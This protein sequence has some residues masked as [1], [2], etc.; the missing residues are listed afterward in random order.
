MFD[1]PIFFVAIV[2]SNALKGDVRIWFKIPEIVIDNAI[3]M[4]LSWLCNTTFLKIEIALYHAIHKSS[5]G[6]PISECGGVGGH[7]S[8]VFIY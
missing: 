2:R 5:G 6:D 7:P 8:F 1:C 3:I 4:T